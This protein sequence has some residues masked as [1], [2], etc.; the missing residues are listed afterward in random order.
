MDPSLLLAF[1]AVAAALVVLP[2]PDWALVLATGLRA[3]GRGLPP[4]I[5]GLAL[6]YV[7]LTG[8]VAAG[9]APLVAA[10]PVALTVLTVVGAAYLVWLG[11]GVLRRPGSATAD[12]GDAGIAAGTRTALLRGL[13][14]SALNP[15]A[16]LFFVAFLPQFTR[17]SAPWPIAVQLLALGGVWIILIAVFYTVLGRSAARLLATHLGLAGVVSRVAGVAMSVGGVA[18]LA[19]QLAR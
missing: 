2:G 9:V 19:E 11:V 12:G 6:G 17:P 13:G 8:A 15:K 5:G 7:V 1:T 16:L 3:S 18:L 10:A 4:T 14:V